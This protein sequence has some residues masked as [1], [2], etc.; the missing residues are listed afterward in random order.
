MTRSRFRFALLILYLGLIFFASSQPYFQPPGPDIESIDKLAHG[1]EYFVLGLLLFAAI[2]RSISRSKP[3][4]FLFLLS[5]GVSI[6]ALD[7]IFQSYIPGREMSI[8]DWIADAVGVGLGTGLAV[9]LRLG[10][11]SAAR[12]GQAGPR[13][14]SGAG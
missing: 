14:G 8:Y 10:K 2:G 6:G 12:P 1:G 3:G 7:E 11:Q 4:T 13:E 9:Q 5:I